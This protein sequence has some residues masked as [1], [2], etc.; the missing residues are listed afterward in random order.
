[1]KV[2]IDV[3]E[4]LRAGT[5]T[6]AEHDKLI[7]LAKKD[8]KNHAFSVIS[9]LAIVAVV[10]GA[11]GLFPEFVRALGNMLLDLF[12]A[13]G[14]HFI[15]ILAAG[16]GALSLGSAFL[17]MLCA[18]GVLTFVG[19]AG[20]FYSHA[21]YLVAIE[22]PTLTVLWF[23]ALAWVA[24]WASLHLDAKRSRVAIVF[25]RSCIFF[26]NLAF[27]VG[28]LWGDRSA[29]HPY[30]SRL[31]FA[32]VWALAL[33]AV[34]AWAANRDKRWVVNTVAV[35]AAIHFYTQWFER[36]GANP[37]SL[38]TAGALALVIITALR[39]YNR[40]TAAMLPA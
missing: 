35:F 6:R 15:L 21:E 27:W 38:V 10:I 14:L 9:V 18:F 30:S 36:L 31:M 13:R 33:V 26:V 32:I 25:S 29:A 5:I 1:V 34:G 39:R 20:L 37:G 17:S 40:G 23:S 12:G 8:T 28:S 16:A 24:Y 4:L 19:N 2:S 3:T 22:E 11:I 7:A